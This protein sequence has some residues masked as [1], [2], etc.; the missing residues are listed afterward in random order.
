MLGPPKQTI[1][2]LKREPSGKEREMNSAEKI[3]KLQVRQ[4]YRFRADYAIAM[5]NKGLQFCAGADA[6]E[7]C[8]LAD[9]TVIECGFERGSSQFY[10]KT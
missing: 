5:L 4:W 2:L 3:A 1:K 8:A 6:N 9:K 10:A 7:T